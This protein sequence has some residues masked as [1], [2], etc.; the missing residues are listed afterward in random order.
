MSVQKYVVN[1]LNGNFT[2]IP[3]KVLQGIRE[4]EALAL[5]CYIAS[6][7]HGW[8]FYKD[9][10]RKHFKFGVK[11]LDNL[12]QLLSK[13]K[14]IRTY[15][16]RTNQGQ[17]G[18]FGLDVFDGNDFS[19]NDIELSTDIIDRSAI[20]AER[21][22]TVG[23]SGEA[24]KEIHTNKKSFSKKHKQNKRAKGSPN[25]IVYPDDF[26]PNAENLDLLNRTAM[27]TNCT[28]NELFEKFERVSKEYNT[29]S[30]DWQS[31][32]AEFLTREKPKRVYEDVTGK[33]KRYD[34]ASPY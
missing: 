31:K 14:L 25:L 28:Q 18:D 26:Y 15:Q 8:T 6:L 13:Y 17:F 23:R 1:K 4:A 32:F 11:K 27:R 9:Q 3:N 22:L 20:S 2:T 19:N 16:L 21:L 34:G 30:N 29:K 5:Y 33:K 24:I 7:P 12:L 10:L